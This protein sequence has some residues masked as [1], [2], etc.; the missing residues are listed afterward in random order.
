MNEEPINIFCLGIKPNFVPG[1]NV[2][3][4]SFMRHYDIY[5]NRPE[6]TVS[7][8][9]SNCDEIVEVRGLQDWFIY[10]RKLAMSYIGE[11]GIDFTNCVYVLALMVI[12]Y[13]AWLKKS[14]FMEKIGSSYSYFSKNRAAEIDQKFVEKYSTDNDWYEMSKNEYGKEI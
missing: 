13:I 2:L 12:I 5:F 14:I 1:P 11:A 7:L 9:R 3:G 10:A 4:G 8:I 6:G